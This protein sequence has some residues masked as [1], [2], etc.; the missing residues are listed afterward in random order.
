MKR[1]TLVLNSDYIPHR[2][3][4]WRASFVLVYSKDN[5]AYTVATYDDVI[6]DS[7]G[8][9]YNIPAVIVLSTYITTNNK[10]A[11]FSKRNIYLRD[12]FTCQYCGGKFDSSRLNIDHI[13]PRSRP[14]KLPK[15]IKMNS[16]ENC[17][18]ACINCNSKKASKTLDEA[19]MRLLRVPRQI[20]RGQKIYYD[21]ISKKVPS[22]WKPYIQGMFND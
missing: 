6:H 5:G 13:I 22:E 9:A 2:V 14:E 17:V 4:D 16:F 7:A 18:T 8:R 20:T 21:I 11:S 12:D 10:K 15:G 19:K 1:S 3:V